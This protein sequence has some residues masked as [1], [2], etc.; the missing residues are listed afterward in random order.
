MLFEASGYRGI[1]A[2]H[3]PSFGAYETMKRIMQAF[4]VFVVGS[5]AAALTA[6]WHTRA[7][8]ASLLVFNK[9]SL[10]RRACL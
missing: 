5:G 10:G 7:Q 9:R 4:D 8:E 6:A 3:S 2:A 1:I